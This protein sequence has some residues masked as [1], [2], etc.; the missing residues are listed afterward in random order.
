MLRVSR[1]GV[2]VA[3]LAAGAAAQPA[4]AQTTTGTITG[5]VLFEAGRDPVHGASIVLVGG[6]RTAVTGE[7]G[8]FELPNVPAGTYELLAQREHFT[9]ARQTVTVT[10]GQTATVEFVLAIS[11]VHEEVTVTG[12][13]G[14]ATTFESFSS[15]TSLDSVEL[16]KDR[17]ATIT[18]ALANQPGIAVRSFGPGSARPIIR[19][20]DG[21]RVLIMQDGVRTGDLSSQSGDHGVTIDPGGLERLEVV[22]G[23]ATLLYGSNAIGGVVNAITPQDAFRA[24]PFN[25]LLGGVSVDAGTGNG[26]GGATGNIQFGRGAWTVWGGGGGR[27]TGDYDAPFAT[28]PNSST[29][30]RNAKGGFG[31]TGA[32]VYT[33]LGV[34]VERSRFGVPFAGEFHHH[35]GEEPGGEDGAEPADIDL[36]SRR[37]EI[38]V[39]AGLRALTNRWL[40]GVKLTL[41]R[42]SYRHDE[43][44]TI[45]GV[46][47][48]GTRFDNDISTLRLEAE[49]KAI[50]RWSGRLG[51]DWL[52]RDYRASGEEALAPPTTQSAFSAFV[53]EEVGWD[54][55]RLQL[56]G[57][58]ERTAYDVSPRQL[59]D[60][61]LDAPDRPAPPDVRDRQFTGASA[62]L[63]VHADIGTAGAFVV[64]LT[65]SSRAPALEELYNFGPHVGN[66]AFE[67]GN[68]NLDRERTLGVDVSLRGRSTR[69]SGEVNVY[70]Y[71]IRDFV[72]LDVTGNE[73][74]GLREAHVLQ[75]DSRFTGAEAKGDIGLVGG[76]RLNGSVSM[77]R[78]RLT[79]NDERLPR[80]PPVSGRIELEIPWRGFTFAPE[81]VL[82]AAQ[83]R[84]FRDET[85]SG[86]YQLLNV[87][88]TYFVARGHATHAIALSGHNLTNRE[89]RLHT[90]FL[91]D[92]APEMG[93]AVKLTYSVR[94]F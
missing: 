31:W 86:A 47:A 76:V 10:A 51:M 35:G 37:D 65:S 33:G 24:S 63:G 11:G 6:R 45:A 87:S 68:P 62:S 71:G 79:T 70:T 22:K 90:S 26:Q 34:Q 19:G 52:G 80:I 61:E 7:D 67:I 72:F 91:K 8:K 43:I 94:F 48:L 5:L 2:A 50:G 54:R 57:R 69:A 39:D 14:A 13:S 28:I 40:E 81:V 12:T 15:V 16:A 32:H 66:L 25:G 75:A 42:T 73:I 92:F 58:V 21:D 3:L 49:H 82:T 17:G 88:A 93:R 4:A 38:R 44:E 64:N 29:R 41:A 46:D 30:M 36:E 84:V 85:P 55:F 59:A 9:A 56:G 1:F 89:H 83:R 74:D 53:Y 60:P 77:V 23:P 27:R 78:A 18:D 20:F